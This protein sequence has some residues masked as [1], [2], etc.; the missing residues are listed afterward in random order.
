[1][2]PDA[3]D[4][5][6]RDKTQLGV[7]PPPQVKRTP[8]TPPADEKAAPDEP[9]VMGETPVAPPSP[10]AS[11]DR[12]QA[13]AA[14]PPPKPA[15]PAGEGTSHGVAPPP[16]LPTPQQP[17]AA[18]APPASPPQPPPSAMPPPA[19]QPPS[20]QADVEEE[21]GTVILTRDRAVTAT[22]QRMQPPG[23]SEVI[24]LDR[25]S[26]LVGRSR[27]CDLPLYSPSASRE[28]ARLTFRDAAWYVQPLGGKTVTANGMNVRDEQRLTHKMRLQLGGD[29][30][31]FLD[32][33]AAASATETRPAAPTSTGR[34][35]SVLVAV[36]VL[37]ALGLAAW[38]CWLCGVR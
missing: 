22:L 26:Y 5:D 2:T 23:H 1:M 32:E 3:S 38:W 25:T 15:A 33:R 28:H 24:R 10:G 4:D 9:P 37:T 14:P 34:V 31:L 17:A 19:H 36:A 8:P 7:A 11:P 12:T 6:K 20:A 13:A 21:E 29:E 18:P 16:K 35:V 27:Q 30:L